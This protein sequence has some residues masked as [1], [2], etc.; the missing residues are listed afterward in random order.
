MEKTCIVDL[1]FL[2]FQQSGA[3]IE[4]S[5][6]ALARFISRGRYALFGDGVFF[7]NFSTSAS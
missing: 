6:A 1:K 4:C 5:A 3:A 7:H 2:S